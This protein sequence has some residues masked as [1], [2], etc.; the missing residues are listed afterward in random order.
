MKIYN[1]TNITYSAIEHN[2]RKNTKQNV[3]ADL[4]KKMTQY[5]DTLSISKTGQ[6]SFRHLSSVSSMDY[7][8]RFEKEVTDIFVKEDTESVKTDSF[9]HHVNRM[10]EVYNKMKNSIEEKY[11]EQDYEPEYYV[12]VK[13][14]DKDGN[15]CP[16]DSRLINFSV[17]G[18]GKYRAGANGDPTSLDL[19]HLPKMH[20]FNGMLTAIVQTNETAGEII[21]TAKAG[22]VKAGSIRLLTK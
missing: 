17:K 11:A 22:G 18:A 10:A 13:V 6:E 5:T 9:E 16:A 21:L 19:F 20:A 12:T 14:V 1:N 15:L 3:P 7:Q 4:E 2:S 8:N